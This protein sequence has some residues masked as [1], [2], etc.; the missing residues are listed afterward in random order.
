MPADSLNLVFDRDLLRRRRD[1]YAHVAEAHEF[2]L[3]RVAEDL[4]ERLSIVTRDFPVALNL[5]AQHGLLSRRIAE[6]GNVHYVIDADASLKLLEHAPGPHVL[7]DE[8]ALP[9]A[10]ES[11]DLVVSGLSLQ[12]VNDLPGTLLQIRRAL[13]PDG[14]LLATLLGGATLQEL[15]HAWLVAEEEVTGGVSPRVAPFADVRELGGLL[16]RA[17][18]ALPVVDAETVTVTYSSPLALMQELKLMGWSNALLGR[19]H[20]PVTR[21]LLARACEVYKEIFA[22]PDG[23]IPA[24]FELITLTAWT[25]HESQQKPLRPGSAQQ[26]LADF[27]GVEER[28]TGEKTGPKRDT[29]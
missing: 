28:Q 21:Q 25:P 9:F 26:R 11:L 4:V 18:F 8:E 1:R 12:F 16:Q 3:E 29:E 23:R 19:R 17:G 13:R 24:T 7:A 15:R 20:Q 2:L 22:T 6:L 10:A 27:L 14:L 5:G